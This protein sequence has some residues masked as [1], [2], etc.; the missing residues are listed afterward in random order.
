MDYICKICNQ[1][2]EGNSHFWENHRQKISDYFHQHEP[3]ETKD[4]KKV[5]FRKDVE[6][7]FSTDFND[8]K[9]RNAWLKSVD[10]E[11]RKEYLLDLLTKR[12]IKKN[13]IYAP[14]QTLLRLSNL[15][16]IISYER[17]F[18]R[19]YSEICQKLGFKI[20]YT[21]K[22]PKIDW[23]SEINIKIDTREQLPLKFPNHIKTE[24]GTLKF[25][26]YSLLE[27]ECLVIERKSLND[28]VST[29]TAGNERFKREIGRAKKAKGYLVVLVESNFS[30]F[31]SLEYLPQM[32]HSKVTFDHASKMARDLYEEFSNLQI[33]FC[34][35]R[36][37]AARIT[38]FIL[39][40]GK[41]V[42]TLDV[43]YLLDSK[44]F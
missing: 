25:G 11:T 39:K 18:G 29:V 31:R 43:Q 36:K 2:I 27:D 32:K 20:K 12:K 26:D 16:H 22:I 28:F 40:V 5:I 9:D 30:N 37:E 34:D 42:K 35:G 19:P 4:G 8:L 14:G 41:K 21:N 10:S 13:W 1:K 33:V 23:N 15:P 44:K 24:I 7:Y 17:E 6:S 3:R 38:E